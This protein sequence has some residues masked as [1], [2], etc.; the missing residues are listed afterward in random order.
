MAEGLPVIVAEADGTQADL[1]RPENGWCVPP[2]DLPALTAALR[3]ALSDPPRLRRMGEASYRIVAEEINLETMVAAFVR[4]VNAVTSECRQL[5]NRI[6]WFYGV[7][8]PAGCH[9]SVRNR[10]FRMVFSDKLLLVYTRGKIMGSSE[11]AGLPKGSKQNAFTR[12]V[13]LMNLRHREPPP[14]RRVDVIANPASGQSEEPLLRTLNNVFKAA[15]IDWDLSITKEKGDAQRLAQEAVA[16]GATAVAVYGGDGTVV[17]AASGL[18]GSQVPLGILPGGTANMMSRAYGIPQDLEEAVSLIARPDH[19]IYPVHLGQVGDGYF[20]QLVGIGMEAKIVEGADRSAKD[21]LGNLAY[22]LAALRALTN[23]QNAHYRLELDDGRVVEE[24][25][26][27]CLIAKTGNL[28]IPSL[29][30]SQKTADPDAALLD[31][32]ILRQANLA[33][34][35]SLATT[36]VSGNVNPEMIP[37]WQAREVTVHTDPPE[38]IQADGEIIGKTPVKVKILQEPIQLIVP[39]GN[40]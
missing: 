40:G 24:D 30:Q 15:G 37:H 34:L 29:E 16:A 32:A 6:E 28:G 26:V 7:V 38:S 5:E 9:G 35:L 39:A 33:G 13:G 4:A 12:V 21:R 8:E 11:D 18:V 25:G 23:P 22:T 1:V 31:I 3:E 20:F 36:V 27:T 19:A 17:E 10:R 2:G 14:H